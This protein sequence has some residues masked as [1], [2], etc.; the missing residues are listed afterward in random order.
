[1]K[2]LLG[3]C[4]GIAAYKAAEIVRALQDR[5]AE[6]EVTMT[7]SA[8]RFI[9]PLTFNALT[10]KHVH[11]G[12]WSPDQ[13]E[14]AEG[15]I[16]HIAVAQTADLL[17]IAPATATTLARLAHGLADDFLSAVYLATTAPVVIA[18]AMNAQMWQHP[19][20]QAN[21]QLLEGRGACFVAPAAGYLACGLTGSGRL[22]PVDAIVEAALNARA[23]KND[24]QGETVL[25]TAGGTR[26]AIDPVRFLGN[27]S[28]GRM[29][30]AL[31]EA[32]RTRGANVILIT[33][34][35]LGAPNGCE[36]VRVQ[37]A[38]Q[39][40]AAMDG[41]LGRAS[42]VIA[43]AAVSDFRPVVRAD[44]KL[45]RSG[46]LTLEL[47]A[48]PDLVA[49]AVAQRRPGTLVIA[50]AA[51]TE[52]LEQ[53]AR[54]KMTRK[55]VDAIVANNVGDPSI[56]FDSSK[57]GGLFLTEHGVVDLPVQSKR[58]MADDILTQIVNLRR[59]A[60]KSDLGLPETASQLQAR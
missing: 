49:R 60:P 17:L 43:A 50:F 28:S 13:A 46:S 18:P 54:D 8:E 56:G 23:P 33:A 20:T 44:R 7:T 41:T 31:A 39:M 2:I 21:V 5:G 22:A 27:R 59:A 14:L 40:G 34:S 53:N 55:G 35:S 19:A 25:V 45:R 4:G 47:E 6:V 52:H 12:L 3:V 58:A 24:L 48:T 32:A 30:H 16:E 36:V 26:E 51:E 15:P 1:M 37:S 9:T 29:G 42:V 10:G 57:N 11:T 38:E